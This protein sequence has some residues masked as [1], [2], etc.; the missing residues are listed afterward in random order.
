MY[1]DKSAF[2]EDEVKNLDTMIAKDKISF[3]ITNSWYIASFNVLCYG[4]FCIALCAYTVIKGNVPGWMLL[5]KLI[6][7]GLQ[8]LTA[9]ACLIL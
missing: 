9:V 5:C 4:I 8:P 1:Y 7:H 3:P 2:T 6:A